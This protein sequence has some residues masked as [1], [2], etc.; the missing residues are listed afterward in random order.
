MKALRMAACG[1]VVAMCLA[2]AA[3]AAGAEGAGRP[4]RAAVTS[5]GEWVAGL[6]ARL[7]ER[8][9]SERGAPR[10]AVEPVGDDGCSIDPDGNPLCNPRPTTDSGCHIDP[11]GAPVCSP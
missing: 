11:S 1:L 4:A 9:G 7:L 2:A 8:V 6:I 10:P 5:T 3:P